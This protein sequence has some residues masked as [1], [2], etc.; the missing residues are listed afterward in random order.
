MKPLVLEKVSKMF[1]GLEALCEFSLEIQQGERRIIIGPNGAGKT[2][3]F[4]LIGGQL[5]QTSGKIFLFGREVTKLLPYQRATLGLSRTFQITNLFSNLTVMENI[6]L[7]VQALDPAKFVL[8][9]PITRYKTF[10]ERTEA[11]LEQWNFCD[12]RDTLIRNLSYGDQRL[13]EIMMALA[14]KPKLLLLDEPTAGLSL[15]ETQVVTSIIRNLDKDITVV[16]IEHDMD[17]AFQ[18]AERITVLQ[19][20]RLL[21]D[22]LPRDIQKD[23]RV[24]EI[25]LGKIK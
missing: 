15:G 14:E 22:G 20:G 3:L 1:G 8:Y 10:I 11:L 25:Y 24:R 19:Q 5:H 9:R 23:P 18:I 16:L 17:V 12:K 13:I 7:A 4:N 2:T 6:L 21:A